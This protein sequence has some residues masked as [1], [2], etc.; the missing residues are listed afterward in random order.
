MNKLSTLLVSLALPATALAQVQQVPYSSE[1]HDDASWTTI[2]VE[3]NS[4]TWVSETS[5]STYKAAD[6][7]AGGVK[8]TY[9]RTYAADDWYVSPAV[10][11]VAGKE[12]KMKLWSKTSSSKEN[13]AVVL[14]AGNTASVLSGGKRLLDKN[15]YSNSTWVKDAVT[16]TVDSTGD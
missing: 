13:Y 14:A 1:L 3:P 10:H 9:D 16:F 7:A 4:K 5:S 2:N 12:Y 8:Y 6:G 15:N 11:L